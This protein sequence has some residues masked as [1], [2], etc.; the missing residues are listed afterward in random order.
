MIVERILAAG[1]RPVMDRPKT[2]PWRSIGIVSEVER[3]GQMFIL[4]VSHS[5]Q[6]IGL[7]EVRAD[8]YDSIE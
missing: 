1:F 7:Q 4:S 3:D 6:E 5:A 8:R 2:E